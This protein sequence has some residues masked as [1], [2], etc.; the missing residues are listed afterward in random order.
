MADVRSPC[1]WLLMGISKRG[2]YRMHEA[3]MKK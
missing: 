2:A 3:E 1:K